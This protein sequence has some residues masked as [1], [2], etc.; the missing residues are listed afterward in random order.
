M[1]LCQIL[2]TAN[3]KVGEIDLDDNIFQVEVKTHVL[4]EVVCMQLAN[5]RRG[6]ASTKT[7]GEVR[8]GGIKPWKQKGTG[9]ARAG[10]RR[11]PLWRGGGTVFGPKPRD[12]H[13]LLPKS[14]RRLALKMALSSRFGE[15]NMIV[16]EEFNLPVL[17]TKE[18][19]RVMGNLGLDECL[20][21]TGDVDENLTRCA[22]NVVGCQVMPVIGLNVY[23]I[24]KYRKL[25][26]TKSCLEPLAARLV[27]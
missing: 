14:T 8:G 16:L 20:V 25:V 7:R 13:Y 22:R 21:V 6:T 23:D 9:R 26:I 12:Y 5:R 19:V 1:A 18:F 27:R 15:G 4:H 10:S 2:N 24:I 11:S 17:K 3:E